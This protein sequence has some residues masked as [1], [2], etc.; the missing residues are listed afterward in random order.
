MQ[1]QAQA[2]EFVSTVKEGWGEI[3][4][5]FKPVGAE[6]GEQEVKALHMGEPLLCP[7]ST[8]LGANIWLWDTPLFAINHPQTVGKP[9]GKGRK[10][11]RKRK[12]DEL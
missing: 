2:R 3:K 6:V 11:K 9:E 10:R 12:R 1:G 8:K 7:T 4:S 5:D